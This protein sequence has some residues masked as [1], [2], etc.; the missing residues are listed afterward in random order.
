MASI[1]SSS[2]RRQRPKFTSICAWCKHT[3]ANTQRL[4]RQNS[5]FTGILFITIVLSLVL[6]IATL[7]PSPQPCEG[8]LTLS[9]L[10]FES[11]ASQPF[12][13]NTPSI[14]QIT[15]T[16]SLTNPAKAP[17][18]LTGQFSDNPALTKITRLDLTPLND[19]ATLQLI[20][21]PNASIELTKLSLQPNTQV[22]K[23]R[24]DSYN[25]RLTFQLHNA[26]NT[27]L[28]LTLNGPLTVKLTDYK[29][30]SKPNL[31][32]DE[33]FTWQPD[34]PFNPTLPNSTNLDIQFTKFTEQPFWGRLAV[35]NVSLDD[36]DIQTEDYQYTDSAILGGTIRIAD[37][38]A[39]LETNQFLNFHPPDS[40]KS[41]LHLSLSEEKT[42]VKPGDNQVLKLDKSAAGLK[43]DFS[44]K[45]KQIE[46]GL[47]P[48]NPVVKLQSSL[49]EVFMSRDAV[50]G[51]IAFLSTLVMTLLGWLWEIATDDPPSPP[52]P[53][54][55]SAPLP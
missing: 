44:G 36:F 22:T 46:I 7:L 10:S 52:P 2:T 43:L 51:L 30:A 19:S 31:S 21:R 26:K 29:I 38:T 15:L 32:L 35:Q 49:L 1:K 3:W 39:S 40:I 13:L 50:I 4:V 24:Y 25:K 18:R 8:S 23:L 42:E 14:K 54:Q 5:R 16:G 48:K 53:S 11:T 45:T 17:L 47:N 6:V 55:P 12:L 28:N 33:P 9:S 41:L 37:K 34:N 20:L 27:Q